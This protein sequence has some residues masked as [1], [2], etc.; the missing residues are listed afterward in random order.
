MRARQA[1]SVLIPVGLLAA[2][3]SS[4]DTDPTQTSLHYN[5]GSYSSQTFQDCYGPS[6][7]DYNGPGDHYVYYPVG[8]RSYKFSNDPGADTKP[9]TAST[10]DTQELS[11]SGTV[12]FTLNTSCDAITDSSGRKWPGGM[13]QKFHETIGGKDYNGRHAYNTVGGRGVGDGWEDLLATYIKDAADRAIDNEALKYGWE[14]LYNDPAK[15][16]QWERDVI[17]AI[18]GLI[19][20]LAGDDYFTVSGIILQK[21]DISQTLKDQLTAKQAAILRGQ[22]AAEDQKVAE[23]W[24]GGIRAYLAYQQ[25]LA[26]NKAIADG[27]IEIL[28]VPQGVEV[29]ITPRG[30]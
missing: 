28:P 4:V 21:P 14:E 16:A 17:K 3:C 23:N 24:P 19:K 15:K 18:P 13:L 20:Q 2:A 10:K 1:V 30:K 29:N 22:A 26:V 27:K 25:Q 7:R 12:I 8:Q 6:K 9:L 5:G 11:V